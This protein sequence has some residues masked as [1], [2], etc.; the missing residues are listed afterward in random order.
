MNNT[1]PEVEGYIDLLREL[2]AGFLE[3]ALSFPPDA[4][5]WR[6]PIPE[7]NSIY[8]LATHVLGAEAWWIHEI[9][10]GQDVRRN[11]PAEFVAEGAD[12]GWLPERMRQV[13]ERSEA[14]LRGLTEA[15][16]RSARTYRERSV[17]AQWGILHII[18]HYSRH[19]GHLELTRQLW[20]TQSGEASD[21][22][23]HTATP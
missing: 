9:I 5:N 23:T 12:L 1:L 6:P 3:A 16:L 13:A 14:V 11:R 7:T 20:D 10:G 21:P 17:T 4:L 22:S 19:L 2:R 18:D 8:V 15:D